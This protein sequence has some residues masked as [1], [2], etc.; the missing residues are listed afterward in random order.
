MLRGQCIEMETTRVQWQGYIRRVRRRPIYIAL[1]LLIAALA[2][3]G[4]SPSVVGKALH[5]QI[6][7]DAVI[8]IHVAIYGIWL[9]LFFAQTVFAAIGRIQ[10]HRKLGKVLIAYG[11]LMALAGWGVTVNRFFHQVRSGHPELAQ[12]ENLAP[13]I[14]MLVFPVFFG[15]AVYH[16]RKPALHKRLMIVTATLLVYPAVV[17]IHFPRAMSH[18]WVLLCIWSSPVLVAMAYDWLKRRLIHPAYVAG[19]LSMGLLVLRYRLI[20]TATW[21]GVCHWMIVHLVQNGALTGP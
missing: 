15:L 16:V 14:D 9:V 20:S 7:H 10:I 12:A 3:A 1:S 13:A 8:H 17:R 21:T 6:P 2:V 19:A 5:H 11:V 4:F 18:T